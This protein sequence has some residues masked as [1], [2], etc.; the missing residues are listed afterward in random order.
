MIFII[1]A[2]VAVKWFVEESRHEMARE[3]ISSGVPLAAPDIA[4]VEVANALQKKA[5]LKQIEPD[6]A[7]KA[8]SVLNECF[9]ELIAFADLLPAALEMS[10]NMRHP[11]YDCLYLACAN[12]VGG[13]L[14]TDDAKFS[15]KCKSIGTHARIILLQD[16]RASLGEAIEATVLQHSDDLVKLDKTASE[17]WEAICAK[18]GVSPYSGNMARLLEP[19]HVHGDSI[20]QRKLLETLKNLSRH[21][22]AALLAVA[23]CGR[24]TNPDLV[25]GYSHAL[26]TL[27]A[28]TSSEIPYLAMQLQHIEVGLA[29]LKVGKEK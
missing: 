15:E 23:W 26:S 14:I 7:R 21:Q 1:D 9:A 22:H 27:G 18:L 16:F 3:L 8:L 19:L 29:K 10:L 28:D 20:P 4:L 6:Q 13:R 12:M 25:Q 11:I 5:S 2:S 17:T 24:G